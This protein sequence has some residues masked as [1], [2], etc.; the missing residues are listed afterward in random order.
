MTDELRPMDHGAVDEL[1]AA[2][3]LGALEPDEARAVAEHLATCPEPHIEVRSLLGIEQVL[4][5]SLEPVQPSAALR[6][7]VMASIERAP[8]E[9]G[10]A[11]VRPPAPAKRRERRGWL[12]WLSPRVARPLALATMVAL[13]AVGAVGLNLQAQ[14]AE[15]DEALRAVA[16]A[17]ASGQTAFRV[18]GDAGRGYV[19][20]TPGDGA[21]L[22]VAELALLPADKIYELW[23]LDAEGTPVAVGTFTPS[24]TEV[25][26]VQ[27]ERD[28][29]GYATF[30][31]TVEASR[32]D[33]PTS[34][35][36]M[37]APLASD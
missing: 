27:L 7:R 30:A 2:F 4:G 3:A 13:I 9:R 25:A 18:E 34:Q 21:V 36:V 17:I 23:L 14:L 8:Q 16:N 37:V 12:D 35:P 26:V 11:A 28:L 22:V 15:R 31:V 20:D 10:A 19:V 33:A 5:V 6:D 29:A 32:V 24:D 1:G